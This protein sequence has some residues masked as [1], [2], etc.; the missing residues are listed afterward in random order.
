M[1]C[2]FI[3]FSLIITSISLGEHYVHISCPN[4]G[5]LHKKTPFCEK[6]SI[7]DNDW[8]WH[9]SL[10]NN[11][12]EPRVYFNQVKDELSKQNKNLTETICAQHML[13]KGYV[14]LR[15]TNQERTPNGY[16]YKPE[17]NV[18]SW[19]WARISKV[20]KYIQV[21]LS[22][23]CLPQEEIK[24][25]Y[26]AAVRG[27]EIHAYLITKKNGVEIGRKRTW[28]RYPYYYYGCH[29]YGENYFHSYDYDQTRS[30]EYNKAKY[31]NFW[32]D[33]LGFELIEAKKEKIIYQ[34]Q[35]YFES[36]IIIY[37]KNGL[38][39]SAW[40]GFFYDDGVIYSVLWDKAVPFKL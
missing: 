5:R 3:I 13:K 37:F 6:I 34:R 40:D 18:T 20:E 32:K 36:P 9:D 23:E 38:Y 11:G 1:N 19:Q 33:T 4:R 29:C 12:G 14:L 17:D 30:F 39:S 28:I 24:T 10:L 31:D 8:T 26:E 22:W 15:I 2:K 27:I 7:L 35:V 25:N 21:E 16:F